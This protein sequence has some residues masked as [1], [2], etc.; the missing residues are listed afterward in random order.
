MERRTTSYIIRTGLPRGDRL[1][2]GRYNPVPDV[3]TVK[4]SQAEPKPLFLSE[5]EVA[6]LTDYKRAADQRR[7]LTDRHFAYAVGASGKP[8]V[9]RTE[10]ERHLLGGGGSGKRRSESEPQLNLDALRKSRRT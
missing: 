6:V 9:L 1:L 8:K 3:A 2:A 7:W 10:V 4:L 5:D